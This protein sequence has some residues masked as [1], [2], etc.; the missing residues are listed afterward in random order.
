MGTEVRNSYLELEYSLGE[1]VRDQED[2]YWI[3]WLN[4][5]EILH[6]SSLK[7][8]ADCLGTL[9]WELVGTNRFVSDIH[10]AFCDKDDRYQQIMKKYKFGKT[11][12]EW[13]DFWKD[14]IR[15]EKPFRLKRLWGVLNEFTCVI[16]PYCQ[17]FI[18]K[19]EREKEFD[20]IYDSKEREKKYRQYRSMIRKMQET[21]LVACDVLQL[22]R[23]DGEE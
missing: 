12:R 20:V 3:I 13:G 4:I 14:L 15:E 1:I 2:A 5:A 21:I 19:W 6:Q 11:I 8:S 18:S 17:D 16:L 9:M 23:G 22:S 7:A 10:W